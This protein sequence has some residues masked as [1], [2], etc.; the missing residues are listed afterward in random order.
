MLYKDSDW[1]SSY[2][3][4]KALHYIIVIISGLSRPLAQGSNSDNVVEMRLH[5]HGNRLITSI[6]YY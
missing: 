4:K 5:F 3:F 1:L 6:K 2:Q